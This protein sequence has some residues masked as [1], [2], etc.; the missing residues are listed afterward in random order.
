MIFRRDALLNPQKWWR[1]LPDDQRISLIKNLKIEKQLREERKM[2]INYALGLDEIFETYWPAYTI[3]LEIEDRQI[4]DILGLKYITLAKTNLTDIDF[5]EVISVVQHLYLNDTR[6]NN[7]QALTGF[8]K[9]RALD[10]STT[11]IKDFRPLSSLINLAY[12]NLSL[13]D[14]HNGLVL[15]QCVRLKKLQFYKTS[16]EYT[17]GFDKLVALEEIYLDCS[18]VKN[19]WG[20]KD[21]PNLRTI[22][23]NHTNIEDLYPIST[24]P[25]LRAIYCS[26]TKIKSLE[27]GYGHP[28]LQFI[29]CDNSLISDKEI[30]N[31]RYHIK[32]VSN[33]ETD[34]SAFDND[35]AK[36]YVA[37]INDEEIDRIRKDLEK[38]RNKR[39]T[40]SQHFMKKKKLC[41]LC[42]Q[43]IGRKDENET[44]EH[45]PMRG[46]FDGYGDEFKI[47]R[48]TVP[49][50]FKCNN[51]TSSID[52]DF[53]NFIASIG[54]TPILAPMA[55]KTIRS[56]LDYRKMFDR[57]YTDPVTGKTGLL[58]DPNI[59][60]EY[61]KKVFRGLFCHQYK[62]P[63]P[64]EYIIKVDIDAAGNNHLSIPFIK[65]YDRNFAYKHS[66]SPYVFR[67]ILQPFRKDLNQLEKKDLALSSSDK[68]FVS[69]HV[70]NNCFVSVVYAH[71]PGTS[72]I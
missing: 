54:E 56:V 27:S 52:E 37:R 7:I 41:F 5:I 2:K 1:S 43:P 30:L 32:D 57:I 10:C 62:I 66:G 42:H 3:S 40:C 17:Y 34:F 12:L 16:L 6:I 48:I 35:D 58:T 25:K 39:P 14:F 53:R 4:L 61:Q 72:D 24:L 67:Y 9:L 31:S 50:C 63:L 15:E 46:L 64:K 26:Y 21:L 11:D 44:V 59:V 45:I 49:S 47:N 28:K 38:D 8:N 13:T 20:L 29:Q 22:F 71:I 36:E 51:E 69:I 33:I 70:Y 65:Y 18:P 23:C 19:L 68:Q 55:D 60:V